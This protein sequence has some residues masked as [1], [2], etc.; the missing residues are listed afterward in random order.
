MFFFRMYL[1]YGCHQILFKLLDNST[2]GHDRLWAY[3]LTN[4]LLFNSND[5]MGNICI[6]TRIVSRNRL[7]YDRS[8]QAM[9]VKSDDFIHQQYRNMMQRK[10]FFHPEESKTYNQLNGTFGMQCLKFR[11]NLLI[12]G[13]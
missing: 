9:C 10:H 11:R 6:W 3:L 4:I 13:L 2:C 8:Q 7:R 1:K 12:N 5:R